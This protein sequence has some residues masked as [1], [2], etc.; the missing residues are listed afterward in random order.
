MWNVFLVSPMKTTQLVLLFY[1]KML[2]NSVNLSISWCYLM[3]K[4]KHKSVMLN[5][6][7]RK[8][9]SG[10]AFSFLNGKK[11]NTFNDLWRMWIKFHHC[12]WREKG[13]TTSFLKV[14]LHTIQCKLD[15]GALMFPSVRV[16]TTP[17]VL[18]NHSVLLIVVWYKAAWCKL[19][20]KG[21]KKRVS[22]W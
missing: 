16:I 17:T 8:M 3:L 7:E 22:K 5:L 21:G 15:P 12:R 4:E 2:W 18:L 14:S 10:D 11:A 13:F 9:F 19:Q 1:L 20:M 6:S